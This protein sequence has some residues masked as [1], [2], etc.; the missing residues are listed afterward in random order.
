M[1]KIIKEIRKNSMSKSEDTDCDNKDILLE[2]SS[3]IEQIDLTEK[4]IN[5][6]KNNSNLTK[7][8]NQNQTLQTAF[9]MFT[10]LNYCPPQSLQ[11]YKK[12]FNSDTTKDILLGKV[13]FLKRS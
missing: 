1:W 13:S 6:T 9:E 11:I 7:T 3:I 12:L 8:L 4:Q 5:D 10:Y 2:T